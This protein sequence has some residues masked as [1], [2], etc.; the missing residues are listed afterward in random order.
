LRCIEFATVG[1]APA[2]RSLVSYKA[3]LLQKTSFRRERPGIARP[4]AA[5]RKGGAI[6]VARQ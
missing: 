4:L 1:L 6:G 3:A 2:G 5:E